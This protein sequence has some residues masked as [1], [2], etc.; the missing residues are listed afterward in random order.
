[1]FF[2]VL[3]NGLYLCI[4]ATSYSFALQ[5]CKRVVSQ[6]FYVHTTHHPPISPTPP[7][8]KNFPTNCTECRYLWVGIAFTLLRAPSTIVNVYLLHSNDNF[9]TVTA[10][11]L[12]IIAVSEEID[13]RINISFYDNRV[14]PFQ[15]KEE[16]MESSTCAV[17]KENAP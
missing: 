5:I 13:A 9:G 1:M 14:P 4:C 7:Q 15:C 2:I 12:N 6:S 3:L 11:V 8:N 10:A 17:E 16:Q